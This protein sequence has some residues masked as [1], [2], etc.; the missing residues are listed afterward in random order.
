ML[1]IQGMEQKVVV[2]KKDQYKSSLVA[3]VKLLSELRKK[4]LAP[5]HENLLRITPFLTLYYAYKEGL[6]TE[7]LYSKSDKVLLKLKRCFDREQM[8]FRIGA[9]IEIYTVSCIQI[10]RVT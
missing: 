2:G 7:D 8:A 9:T 6:V 3:F 10:T 5:H 4:G 1:Y